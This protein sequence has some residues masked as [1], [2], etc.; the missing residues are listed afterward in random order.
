MAFQDIQI[1]RMRYLR[2]PNIWTYRP[3][4]EAW[5]DIGELENHPSNTIAGFYDRLQTLLP[6]LVEHRCGIDERGGFLKR[7]QEGTWP[8]H[9]MEHVAIEL[10][11]LAGMQVGFGKARETSRRGV[12]KVVI[13][14][15][16]KE[17]GIAALQKARDIVMATINNTAYDLAST[18]AQFKAMVDRMCL[19]PSTACIVDAATDRGIPFIRLTEGNL[20]QL[21][22]GAKQR[23][24]WTAETDST[25][26]ISETISSDKDLTK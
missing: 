18:V 6:G 3:V 20:V 8:G 5:V 1:L 14:T 2:G 22:Y 9:I 12:Y 16:Q 19:G 7:L 24:I 4:V 17:I 26:A 15:R 23:R 21:G 11:N 10:Q 25:S 13:R